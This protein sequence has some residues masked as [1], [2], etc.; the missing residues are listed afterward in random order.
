VKNNALAQQLSEGH[1]REG[2]EE[3]AEIGIT[4]NMDTVRSERGSE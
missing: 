3:E 4:Q 1:C 2:E